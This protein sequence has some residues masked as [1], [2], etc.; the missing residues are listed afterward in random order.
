MIA[1]PLTDE[2][3]RDMVGEVAAR[4]AAR[5]AGTDTTR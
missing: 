4:R 5:A 1:Y 3:F 2:R